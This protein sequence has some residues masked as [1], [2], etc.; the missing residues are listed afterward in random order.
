M[1]R[2]HRFGGANVVNMLVLAGPKSLALVRRRPRR[3]KSLA[4]VLIRHYDARW[5]WLAWTRSARRQARGRSG[6]ALGSS[7]KPRRDGAERRRRVSDCRPR[8]CSLIAASVGAAARG[9]HRPGTR[10]E[11]KY[12]R[13][14][15]LTHFIGAN[16]VARVGA[17]RAGVPATS[18]NERGLWRRKAPGLRWGKSARHVCCGAR[19]MWRHRAS[20][21][22]P[23]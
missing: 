2:G 8:G 6:G 19:P 12:Q 18:S 3:A 17:S 9:D 11:P 13:S 5:R 15:I 23:V 14:L 21:R 20:R 10:S 1:G 22:G 7:R 4:F 16:F